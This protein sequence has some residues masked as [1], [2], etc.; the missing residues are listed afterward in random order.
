M[1]AIVRR[2]RPDHNADGF[3]VGSRV[4]PIL[5]SGND[6]TLRTGEHLTLTPRYPTANRQGATPVVTLS[7]RRRP[8]TV[9]VS[10]WREFRR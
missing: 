10:R 7:G 4:L 2:Y 1:D 5:G 3:G 8:T 9:P 6:V